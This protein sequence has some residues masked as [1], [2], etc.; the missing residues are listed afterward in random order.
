MKRGTL[1]VIVLMAAVVGFFVVQELRN[2]EEDPRDAEVEIFPWDAGSVVSIELRRSGETVRVEKRDGIWRVSKPREMPANP[3]AV[4]SILNAVHP[5]NK[6]ARLPDGVATPPDAVHGLGTPALEAILGGVDGKSARIRFG[7]PLGSDK[8][9]KVYV[10]AGDSDEVLVLDAYTLRQFDVTFAK[11]RDLGLVRFSPA[12]IVSVTAARDGKTAVLARR[13]GVWALGGFVEDLADPVLVDEWAG[14]ASGVEGLQWEA[15]GAVEY[16]FDAPFLKVDLALKSRSVTLTVGAPTRTEGWRWV[17]SSEYPGEVSSLKE[18][19]TM[20]LGPDP[21]LLRA[22]RAIPAMLRDAVAFELEGGR[23]LSVRKTGE[24]WEVLRPAALPR[25][26]EGRIPELFALLGTATVAERVPPADPPADAV[27]LTWRW[28]EGEPFRIRAW[29]DGDDMFVRSENPDRQVRVTGHRE[30]VRIQAGPGAIQNPDLFPDRV[31][32]QTRQIVV[33]R[34]GAMEFSAS[35]DGR[36]WTLDREIPGRQ[37]DQQKIRDFN[38]HFACP[39]VE[40]WVIRPKTDPEVGLG[41]AP[42]WRVTVVPDPARG[43]GEPRTILVGGD[44]PNLSYYGVVDG[45]E[46][47]FLLNPLSAAAL[48]NG[49]WKQ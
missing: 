36:T 15:R 42:R 12:D 33:E 22:R 27:T 40:T 6:A 34:D 10:R 17:E 7:L 37:L 39:V 48:R 5:L 25:V 49:V 41:A 3:Q 24:S 30:W 4:A 21:E 9:E 2:R 44:G 32:L 19:D 31:P 35:F 29:P 43:G 28:E 14:R 18:S 46:D 38:Q 26:F 16:G 20:F 8:G 23:P 47:V 13:G 1:V 45:T 11:V